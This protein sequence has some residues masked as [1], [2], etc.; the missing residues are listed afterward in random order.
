M[1]KQQQVIIAFIFGVVFVVALL[2]LAIAFPTP[3]PFQYTVFRIVLALAAAG[4]AAMIPGFL[5]VELSPIKS[6]AIRAG[7]A[8]AVFVIVYFFNPAGLAI[9]EPKASVSITDVRFVEKEK[10]KGYD[11]HEF[12]QE[13][14]KL[15]VTFTNKGQIAALL[16]GCSIQV[17]ECWKAKPYMGTAAVVEP[18]AEYTVTLPVKVIPGEYS[19]DQS[20]LHSLNPSETDS[21]IIEPLLKAIDTPG[22]PGDYG[23]PFLYA[24]VIIYTDVGIKVESEPILFAVK[25]NAY[26]DFKRPLP[27]TWLQSMSGNM[28]R[29]RQAIDEITAANQ[30]IL[31][32]I[33]SKG[34]IRSS[35][36]EQF[37]AL[38][39]EVRHLK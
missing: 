3:T 31:A 22:E 1:K 6:M 14:L 23:E 36:I 7:G 34:G 17:L 11:G 20:F 2:V 4:V 25:T 9:E 39:N 37:T 32:D 35:R 19:T 15:Q 24:R 33:N 29:E 12:D 26:W 16:R 27:D 5:N 28:T 13:T 38:M 30:R 10:V 8:V 21:V 18:S